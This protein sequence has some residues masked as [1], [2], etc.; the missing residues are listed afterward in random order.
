MTRLDFVALATWPIVEYDDFVAL[1]LPDDG[2]LDLGAADGGPA[3]LDSVAIRHK[4]NIAEFNTIAYLLR[5]LFDP[6][7]VA[8]AGAKLLPAY[9]KHCVHGDTPDAISETRFLRDPTL[10]RCGDR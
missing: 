4:Q 1:V 6:N 3:H 5:Q 8:Y 7:L 9:F 10:L 2:R